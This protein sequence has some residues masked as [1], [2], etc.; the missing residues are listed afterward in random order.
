VAALAVAI[1]GTARAESAKSVVARLYKDFAWQA[2]S[3]Q[4]ELFG[5]VL[6]NQKKAVLE[7]YFSPD[8]AALL[9][10]DAA[11]QAKT[12]EICNLDF[13]PIF[14][15]Q[16]PSVTDLEIGDAKSNTVPVEF[17]SPASNDAV[18]VNF[19][20]TMVGGAWKISDITYNSMKQT[21]LKKLLSKT[22]Q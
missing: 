16:D 21:S 4:S 19:K 10:Q 11:C 18:R 7:R 15:S 2:L 8:L 17:K 12:R 22:S 20:M 3:S 5:D 13:D 9:L 6:A 14:A 1:C